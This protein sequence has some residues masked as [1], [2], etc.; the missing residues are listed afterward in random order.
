M[1]LRYAKRDELRRRMSSTA[2]L[3]WAAIRQLAQA[4]PS[5]TLGPI[6][7]VMTGNHF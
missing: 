3:V 5:R 7:R 4:P 2:V 1:T 6:L